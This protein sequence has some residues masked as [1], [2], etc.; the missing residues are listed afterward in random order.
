MCVAIG[1]LLPLLSAILHA[2][3]AA[4]LQR[5]TSAEIGF[6]NIFIFIAFLPPHFQ[7]TVNRDDTC[8]LI[9]FFSADLRSV[10]LSMQ[11]FSG[12]RGFTCRNGW[13]PQLLVVK[14]GVGPNWATQRPPRPS[15]EYDL[16]RDGS[17]V[18]LGSD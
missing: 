2:K 17:R 5:V 6:E 14:A 9:S 7:R 3:T 11:V 1:V 12:K 18:D 4:V 8:H 16:Q 13:H 15:G 10:R